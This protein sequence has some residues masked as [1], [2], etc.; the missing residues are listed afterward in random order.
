ME[1]T[2][3]TLMFKNRKLELKVVNTKNEPTEPVQNDIRFE[4]K[5]AIAATYLEK[6]V[7]KV[8]IMV[9]AFVAIDTF[10]QVMVEHAKK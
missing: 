5:A 3:R 2:E 8:G 10:R 4:E 1:P 9:V 6:I 7:G